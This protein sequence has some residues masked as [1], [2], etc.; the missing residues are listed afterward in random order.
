ME[1]KLLS[2]RRI[3]KYYGDRGYIGNFGKGY[4]E[5]IVSPLPDFSLTAAPD[6][7]TLI[8]IVDKYR[9]CKRIMEEHESEA[10]NVDL[11]L[12]YVGND[13]IYLVGKNIAKE[14]EL[15]IMVKIKEESH[16]E[17]IK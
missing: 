16:K 13:G 2:S 3:Q 10:E 6:I 4:A 12:N 15:E 17:S 7:E 1:R 5:L 14:S 9:R 11:S 8:E